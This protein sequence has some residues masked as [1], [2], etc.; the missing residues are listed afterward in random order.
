MLRGRVIIQSTL[1][2][3]HLIKDSLPTRFGKMGPLRNL[4]Q[5]QRVAVTTTCEQIRWM[6]QD[7]VVSELRHS[8]PVTAATLEKVQLHVDHSDEHSTCISRSVP[9]QFVLGAEQSLELF[10]KEFEKLGLLEKYCLNSVGSYY[11]LTGFE[12]P[13]TDEATESGEKRQ[14]PAAA[15]TRVEESGDEGATAQQEI[16]VDAE[17]GE[18]DTLN[19]EASS[20]GKES[21]ESIA[22]A[23]TTGIL[24][25]SDWSDGAHVGTDSPLRDSCPAALGQDEQP[26]EEPGDQLRPLSVCVSS[27][28][29]TKEPSVEDPSTPLARAVEDPS[30]PLARAVEGPPTRGLAVS[31][32]DVKSFQDDDCTPLTSPAQSRPRPASTHLPFWL[33]MRI[34]DNQVAIFFHRR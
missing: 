27:A 14:E 3:L 15:G 9:L 18:L 7:E 24:A 20:E 6:L 33:F 2:R 25:I 4:S 21:D 17:T 19:P 29:L 5:A 22:A 11:Y 23:K 32:A 1:S 10:V 13:E 31:L 26:A 34:F 28:S 30:T 12:A 16:K 8:G